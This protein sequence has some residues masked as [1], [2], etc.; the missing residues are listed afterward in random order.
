VESPVIWRKWQSLTQNTSAA[1]VQQ[2]RVGPSK[3]IS[4]TWLA[5]D[6][7]SC[8]QCLSH[9]LMAAFH[10]S[11]PYLLAYFEHFWNRC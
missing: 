11:S 5:F 1:I 9:V 8:M 4:S 6:R 10:F 7:L 2:E 3:G